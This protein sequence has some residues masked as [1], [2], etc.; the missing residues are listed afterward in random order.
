MPEFKTPSKRVQSSLAP[1]SSF[2]T[3]QE[4]VITHYLEKRVNFIFRS[5]L[6]LITVNRG[7][8]ENTW[9]V[10]LVRIPYETKAPFRLK[11]LSPREIFFL[12]NFQVAFLLMENPP[13]QYA[14]HFQ[15]P[16]KATKKNR[17]HTFPSYW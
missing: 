7:L 9:V 5:S 4:S 11:I 17:L 16:N 14:V 3:C 1:K 10:F 15:P 2:P 8:H 6:Q 13:T 12:D